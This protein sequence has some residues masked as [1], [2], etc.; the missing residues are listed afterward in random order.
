L[1]CDSNT[2]N[3]SIFEPGLGG[4]IENSFGV[5]GLVGVASVAVGAVP[6]DTVLEENAHRMFECR[7]LCQRLHH[8]RH[9]GWVHECCYKIQ[10]GTVQLSIFERLKNK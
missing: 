6:P 8:R 9:Y 3:Q 2:F 7:Q 1:E 10:N 5:P 4:A